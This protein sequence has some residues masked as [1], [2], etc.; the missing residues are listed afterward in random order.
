MRR[1]RPIPALITERRLRARVRA[2]GRTIRDDYRNQPLVLVGVLKGSFIFMADLAREIGIPLTCDFLRV[3]SYGSGTE[4]SGNVRLEFDVT[5]PIRGKHV[6]L[7][8]DIVDTGLTAKAVLETLRARKPASLRLCSL[9]R[10]PDR[11]RIP[12]AVDYLGFD[13]PDRFV[14]GYGLDHDG[15][16]RNLPYLGVWNGDGK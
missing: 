15:L 13:I 4:S 7:V 10:K 12:V 11:A 9:L 8:E 5:Q 3:S 16:H 2:L 6:L 14:V 1:N